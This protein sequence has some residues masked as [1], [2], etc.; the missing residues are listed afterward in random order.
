[1]HNFYTL[2][3]LFFI[4]ACN[5]TEVEQEKCRSLVQEEIENS[6]YFSELIAFEKHLIEHQLL[7]ETEKEN[8]HNLVLK[9]IEAPSYSE[10]ILNSYKHNY[11][12]SLKI[13]TDCQY[14]PTAYSNLQKK[15][16]DAYYEL[17]NDPNEENLLQFKELIKD[18]Y[19]KLDTKF[20]QSRLFDYLTLHQ[21]YSSSLKLKIDALN[22]LNLNINIENIFIEDQVTTMATLK[23]DLEIVIQRKKKLLKSLELKDS[24]NVNMYVNSKVKM[25]RVMDI[26]AIIRSISYN[27]KVSNVAILNAD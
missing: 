26:R 15:Y 20:V 1:M 21:L 17:E 5:N 25:G 22:V 8:Y 13:K 14:N 7:I 12:Y 18:F 23:D 10:G 19:A 11:Q 16:A 27:N 9:I 3:I 24:L 2:L 6:T 4:T